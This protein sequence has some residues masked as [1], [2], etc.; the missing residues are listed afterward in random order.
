[1]LSMYGVARSRSDAK[2][3]SATSSTSSGQQFR[4]RGI[5]MHDPDTGGRKNVCGHAGARRAPGVEA[6]TDR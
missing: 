4:E 5:V 6:P 1:M 2:P 3:A